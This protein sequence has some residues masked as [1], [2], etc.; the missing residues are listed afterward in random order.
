MKMKIAVIFVAAF[1]IRFLSLDQSLWLDEAVTATAVTTNSFVTLFT[2]FL[3]YD[4]HPPFYYLLMK[5]VTLFL[6]SSEVVLRLPSVLFS[7]A[8]GY[9]VYKIVKELKNESAGMWASVFF[10]FNP[11]IVYYSQEARMYMM[12]TFFLTA[13]LYYYLRI[14]KYV[15]ETKM[16][17]LVFF[18]I[19]TALGLLTFYGSI[20]FVAA[21]LIHRYIKTK[22]IPLSLLPGSII[23]LLVLSPLLL[24]QVENA[25]ASLL[26]VTNWKQVLGTANIKNAVLI[27]LKFATGRISMEPKI[28][29]F[30]VSGLWTA[31]LLLLTLVGGIKNR[32]LIVI[33]LLTLA[34]GFLF[35]F[36]TPV[37]QYFRFLY[38]IPLMVMLITLG[39]GPISKGIVI[40]GC[41]IFSL[42]YVLFPQFHREDWKSLV[43][44]LP[45]K[46]AV[47]VILPS[48]DPLKYYIS[49]GV[50]ARVPLGELREINRSA[51]PG[52]FVIVP[53]TAD[54][55]G[56]DYTSP[57]SKSGHRLIEKVSVRGL[58]YEVWQNVLP[59][60]MQ[61]DVELL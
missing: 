18:N 5:F 19:F 21:V 43:A 16:R 40:T 49:Q 24:M 45:A 34:I 46:D 54:I 17:D 27:P 53:Y 22:K 50:H 33:F 38:L 51:L 52:R 58:Q 13:S 1:F 15:K 36:V 14:E 3:R 4:F 26:M 59:P 47:Y 55:Y 28:I 23:S 30:A 10:L 31:F 48:A 2:Q 11:L 29:F 61:V 8:T 25:R 9:V 7:L 6:G 32:S 60:F 41:L 35:S 57:L 37:L 20:F 44:A 12:A 42:S 56:F 39:S